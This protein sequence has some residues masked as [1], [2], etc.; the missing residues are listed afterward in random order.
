MGRQYSSGQNGHFSLLSKIIHSD[1]EYRF[2][3]NK[4]INQIGV[5]LED[6]Q[7]EM[8]KNRVWVEVL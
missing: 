7:E 4:T 6:K 8:E 3:N 5:M 1:K 2:K